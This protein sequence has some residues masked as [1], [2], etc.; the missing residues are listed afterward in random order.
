MSSVVIALRT[1]LM[2]ALPYFRSEDRLRG[3]LLL[4]GVIAAELGL[5]YVAVIMTHWNARFFNALEQRS[6]ELL[7]PELINL[8]GLVAGVAITT[9]SQ[10]YFGQSLIIRWR[11]WMTERYVGIWMADARHYRINFVDQNI[12]NI[13]LRIANDVLLFVQRTHELGTGLLGSIV[14]L[15]SF[16]YILWGVSAIMPLPLFGVDL[17]FPGYLICFALAFAAGGTLI[18]HYIGWRL[19]PLNFNQ[20]RRESDFRFA[21]ARVTDQAEPVALMGGEAVERRELKQPLRPARGQLAPAGAPANTPDRLHRRLWPYLDRAADSDRHAGLSRRCDPA[22]RADADRARLPA[23]R[24]RV[25]ILP[26]LLQQDRGMA[27]DH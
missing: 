24:R 17:S 20:Q 5:V 13:H 15:L 2:L 1:F 12:D 3:R 11:K 23:R 22:R 19:I 4:A 8:C 25:R 26:Q 14:A 16:A 7:T 6:W 10:Y 18:A 21:I 9:M 27:G